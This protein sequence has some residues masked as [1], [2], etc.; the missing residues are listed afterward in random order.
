MKRLIISGTLLLFA[1][2]LFAQSKEYNILGRV[3]STEDGKKIFL[4]ESSNFRKIDSTVIKD[5]QFTFKGNIDTELLA[6]IDIPQKPAADGWITPMSYNFILEPGTIDVDFVNGK[7]GG[8]PLNTIV[9]AN[10]KEIRA[11]H[12]EMH[13]RRKAI[14]DDKS[15]SQEEKSSKIDAL[16]KETSK[17]IYDINIKQLKQ[18]PNNAVGINVVLGNLGNVWGD[19]EV[20]FGLLYD[21]AGPRVREYPRIE[22]ARNK[23]AKLKETG[24]GQDFVDFHL[25][26]GNMDGTPASFS[27]YVGKG[28]YVLVDFWASWCGPCKMELPNILSIYNDYKGDKFDVLSVAVWDKRNKT[29]ESAKEHNVIWNQMFDEKGVSGKL[30]GFESI[31]EIILFG[32]DGKIIDR[33][34]RSI[35]IRMAVEKA[36]GIKK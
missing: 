10:Q 12:A 4:T 17:L 11:I 5:G 1:V 20:L 21:I 8:T 32:P 22:A 7:F 26:D 19:D 18:N 25:A 24:A 35:E 9:A 36:L 16:S 23:F 27:D 15:L 6:L 13:G 28:K 2:S 14:L 29:I 33:G 34:M 30:Y 31:P 3:P